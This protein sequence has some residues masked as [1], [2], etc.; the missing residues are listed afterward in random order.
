MVE[1]VRQD[2]F[3]A[4]QQESRPARLLVVLCGRPSALS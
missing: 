1:P 2:S 4:E 3:L